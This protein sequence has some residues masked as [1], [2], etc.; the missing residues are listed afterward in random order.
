MLVTLKHLLVIIALLTVGAM[1]LPA[2]HA[3]AEKLDAT[4]TWIVAAAIVVMLAPT[5]LL[6]WPLYKLLHLR[7][8]ILPICPHCKKRHGNYHIPA[9]AWPVAI[10]LCWHCGQPLRLL[11]TRHAPACPEPNLVSVNLRWPQFIGRWHRH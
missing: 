8:L 10:L 2:V 3:A 7:P 5:I 11:L 1:L 9:D 6:S 4:S